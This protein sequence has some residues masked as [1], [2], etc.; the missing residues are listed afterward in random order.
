MPIS[1]PG[2]RPGPRRAGG[3]TLVELMV[4]ILVIALA[5]GAAVMAM[6]D[7]AGRVRAEAARFAVRAAAARD[8]AIVDGRPVSLWVTPGGYGFEERRAGGWVALGDRPLRVARWEEGTRVALDAPRARIVFDA[9]G[10]ADRPLAVAL[11]RSGADAVARIEA[12]G[13]THAE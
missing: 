10:L 8:R 13:R 11:S 12:D 5:A 6:P 3:F 9:T 2:N 7:P 1:A 4:V